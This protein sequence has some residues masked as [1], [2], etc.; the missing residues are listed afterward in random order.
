MKPQSPT[1]FFVL[2][3]AILAIAVGR[4]GAAEAH[5]LFERENLV[6]WCIV[7][8]DGKQRTPEQRAEMLERLGIKHFAY[9]FRPE[10]HPTFERELLALQ[11][12]RIDLLSVNSPSPQMLALLEKYNLRPQVWASFAAAPASVTV[13][14][15][16]VKFSVAAILPLV[17]KTRKMGCQLGLYAHGG[18]SGY[19]DNMIAVAKCLRKEHGA[20]HVGIVYNFHW[21]HNVLDR[22]PSVMEALKPYLICLNINGMTKNGPAV[23]KMI[24]PLGQGDL[25]LT[26]LKQIRGSG[27]AGPIGILNHS[28]EDAELRLQ[29]NLDGLNWL[30]LQLDGKPVGPK[31]KP[32]SWVEPAEVSSRMF[33]RSNLASGSIVPVD[34]KKRAPEEQ[35]AMLEKIGIRKFVGDGRGGYNAQWDDE[36]DALKRHQI[37]L[38]GWRFPTTLNADAKATLELFKRHGLKPQLW[39]GGSGGPVQVKDAAD[40]EDRL[41]GEVKRLAPIAIAAAEIGCTVG[42]TNEGDWYGEPANALAIVQ[43]LKAQGISNVG[44]VYNMHHGPPHIARLVGVLARNLPHL[45]CFNLNTADVGGE[46][47]GRQIPPLG[48]G[49]D[50]LHVLHVLRESAYRGPIGILNSTSKDTAARLLDNLDGLQWLVQKLD[51]KPPG[52]EPQYR[53]HV[54]Q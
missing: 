36:L 25:D 30:A 32:R 51:G 6:A 41:Q 7:P 45:L 16:R 26:L 48:V 38:L 46:A 1:S 52:P 8:F 4:L 20:S 29:D 54:E 37:E 15:E 18:W 28:N 27:Y 35:A 14:E 11:K 39:V 53:T 3:F 44:I 31:P 21:A 23:G 24:L 49:S 12:H 42:L 10:H 43:T 9:D 13:F 33:A 47:T 19:P 17:E 34:G 50:D 22:F 5:N 40:Q 2:I